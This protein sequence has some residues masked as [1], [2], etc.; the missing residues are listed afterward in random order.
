MDYHMPHWW[1][2]ARRNVASRRALHD[3]SGGVLSTENTEIQQQAV[4]ITGNDFLVKPV[5]QAKLLEVLAKVIK[6]SSYLRSQ[7][8]SVSQ[9]QL[10]LAW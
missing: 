3:D 7:I 9:Y 5:D 2:R 8:N 1:R 10:G 4:S 6:R